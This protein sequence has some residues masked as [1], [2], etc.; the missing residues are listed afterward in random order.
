MIIALSAGIVGFLH[1]LSPSHWLP[2]ILLSKTHHWSLK[3]SLIAS[4][5]ASSGHIF[6]SIV[7]G[8]AGIGAGAHFLSPHEEVIEKFSSI[9]LVIFGLFYASYAYFSHRSCIGHTHHGPHPTR[10]KG[11]LLFLLSL[12]FSPCIAVFPLFLAAAPLGTSHLI[13]TLLMFAI[14]V[15]LALASSTFV[16]TLGILK[17]DHPFLEHYGDVLTGACVALMGLLLFFFPELG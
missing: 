12:G 2:V 17:L 11:P 1:S 6:L 9:A 14:G 7:L 3:K 13:F 10:E 4:L 15:V 5:V 8:I 16:V